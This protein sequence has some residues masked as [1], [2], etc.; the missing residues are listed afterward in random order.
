[1]ALVIRWLLFCAAWLV[2]GRT[3][4]ADLAMGALAAALAAPLSLAL[5]PPVSV[6]VQGVMR[7]SGRFARGSLL[8]G[9]DV[10]RRVA[11]TPVRVRPGVR[12]VPVPL[13]PGLGRA[14]FCALASLQ[15]GT[16][17]LG[18]AAG[19]LEVHV[20]DTASHAAAQLEQDARGFRAAGGAHS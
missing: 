11:A 16:L 10:A 1:M 9:I 5:L 19:S 7:L 8:A 3:G 17:P 20:L 13:E 4:P 18:G 6:S 2:L 15:P 14:A 12:T